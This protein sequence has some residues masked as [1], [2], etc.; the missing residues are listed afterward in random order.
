MAT[1]DALALLQ[2][3]AKISNQESLE[4][5]LEDSQS[6]RA[7]HPHTFIEESTGGNHETQMISAGEQAT[8]ASQVGTQGPTPASTHESNSG[9]P[10]K[11]E[12]VLKP[13]D[14]VFQGTF[15]RNASLEERKPPLDLI[16]SSTSVFFRHIHPWFPFLDSHLV[17]H[18]LADFADRAYSARVS[19]K[20]G[21]H[22]A[23]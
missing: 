14:W 1:A 20:L 4:A 15:A 22:M 18:D 21:S 10:E 7:G 9:G 17:L 19:P 8:R 3:V 2:D 11:S 16:V 13:N 6:G 5:Q 12:A 23:P